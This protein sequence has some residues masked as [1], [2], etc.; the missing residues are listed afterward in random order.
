MGGARRPR[1]WTPA[2]FDD[3]WREPRSARYWQRTAT[4]VPVRGRC[5][6]GS[7][8]FRS[9]EDLDL[10]ED[11]GPDHCPDGLVCPARLP[12]CMGAVARCRSSK[13]TAAGTVRQASQAMATLRRSGTKWCPHRSCEPTDPLITQDQMLYQLSYLRGRRRL[14]HTRRSGPAC[15]SLYGAGFCTGR[16]GGIGVAACSSGGSRVKPQGHCGRFRSSHLGR[17]IAPMRGLIAA[18]GSG[19]SEPPTRGYADDRAVL[20]R[21]GQP[22]LRRKPACVPRVR[23]GANQR[24]R[25]PPGLRCAWRRCSGLAIMTESQVDP[26]VLCRSALRVH[27]PDWLV[28]GAQ[29]SWPMID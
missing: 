26:A 11:G 21:I 28:M 27:Q 9:C 17:A 20:I 7:R 6:A 10:A 14:S 15:R 5:P 18:L 2:H 19:P 24:G 22:P 3:L 29:Q 25:N 1:G 13:R 12:T 23:P 4:P 8:H 16:A